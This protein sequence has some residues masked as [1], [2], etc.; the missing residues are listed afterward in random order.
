MDTDRQWSSK[1]IHTEPNK[2]TTTE[3]LLTLCF[4][5]GPY[6]GY[7]MRT[8]PEAKEKSF[9]TLGTEL[10]LLLRKR[11][12]YQPSNH[13]STTKECLTLHFA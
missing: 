4:L 3:E 10:E 1:H 11:R 5:C 12:I 13:T 6:R 2:Q 7:K 9:T 8:C